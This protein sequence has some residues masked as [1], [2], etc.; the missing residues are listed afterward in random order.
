MFILVLSFDSEQERD[1][2][3]YIF[4]KYRKLM[5]HKAYGILRD[6]HLAEDAASEAFIRI[7]K[8]IHKI[9]DPASNQ[10]IAF[11]VTIVKNTALT[12]LQKVQ[13]YATEEY[14]EEQASDF[15]L[16]ESTISTLGSERIYQMVDSLG[17]EMK[18]VFI[19]RYTHDMSHKEIG[20]MLGISENNVTVRLHRAKKK[21][22]S[23]LE[24]SSEGA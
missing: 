21:L 15:D 10:T 18:S 14:D 8:N 23:M 22:A 3:E 5:L 17:E 16:E 4:A 1:K 19:L 7:Y 9:G 12:M 20:E 6:Y 24:E 2:F 13:N 11:V